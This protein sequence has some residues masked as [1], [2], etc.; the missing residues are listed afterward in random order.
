LCAIVLLYCDGK[1][2][3]IGILNNE[4]IYLMKNNLRFKKLINVSI[5]LL[6]TAI[7][8]AQYATFD[9]SFVIWQ[10]PADPGVQSKFPETVAP[11]AVLSGGPGTVWEGSLGSPNSWYEVVPEEHVDFS[12]AFAFHRIG[13][14]L[15]NH[16]P[17]CIPMGTDWS[18]TGC[19]EYA[20]DFFPMVARVTVTARSATGTYTTVFDQTITWEW[21]APLPYGGYGFYWWHNR[22]LG[23]NII[24][25]GDM[26]TDNWQS[27]NNYH[28][29]EFFMRFE[30]ISQPGEGDPPTG[31]P[32]YTINYVNEETAEAVSTDDEYSYNN[33]TYYSGQNNHVALTPGQT[34]YFRKKADPSKKQT[35]SVPSRP[36]I[37]NFTVDYVNERTSE[38]AS[39]NIEFSTNANL[40]GAT[41]GDGGYPALTPGVNMYF[42]KKATSS[43]FR[44]NI[45]SLT[46]P[47]RPGSPAFGIN[48]ASEQ[49]SGAVSSEYNYSVNSDMSGASQGTGAVLALTPGTNMYF[50]KRAIQGVAFRSQVQTLVVPQRPAGPGVGIDYVNERTNMVLGSDITYSPNS[51]MSGAVAGT[52]SYLTLVPGN[53][54]FFQQEATA[55]AF[56]TQVQELVIPARPAKPS[57]GIDY[58]NERTSQAI[59]SDMEYSSNAAMTSPVTG[60]GSPVALSPGTSKFFRMKAGASS[61]RSEIQELQ[62][63][64]R[65]PAPTFSINYPNETT[66]ETVGSGTQYSTYS[67]MSN[68]STGTGQVVNV[69]PG[70]NLYLRTMA[71]ASAFSSNIFQLMVPARPAPP[72]Y[73]IDYVNETTSDAVTSTDQYGQQPD[74][75]DAVSGTGIP[76]Q[77]LPGTSLYF[78]KGAT[79]SLF[80]SA[81]QTLVV[82]A[83]P[84]APAFAIDF[85]HEQTATAVTSGFRYSSNADMSGAVTGTGAK[86]PVAPLTILYFQKLPTATDFMSE[87]QTL[88]APGRPM[89]PSVGIDFINERTASAVDATLE[90]SL[91][92]NMQSSAS[93]SGDPIALIPGLDMYFRKKATPTGFAS[94][95]QHLDVPDRPQVTSTVSGTTTLYPFQVQVN[96][97][98]LGIGLTESGF[99]L[100]N[101]IVSNL[102]L[103]ASGSDLTVY[104]ADIRAITQDLVSIKIRANATQMGNFQSESFKV[105]YNG[106]ATG[107]EE[108]SMDP[109]FIEIYPNPS[110]G[111]INLR[112]SFGRVPVKV[113]LYAITGKMIYTGVHFISDGE[114]IDLR[115]APKGIYLI[116]FT[117]EGAT[118]IKKIILQ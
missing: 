53:T 110:E 35:L 44:S 106:E 58:M 102:S 3:R 14:V 118:S 41:T 86:V 50:Q 57:V 113:E 46:V 28:N 117:A 98:Q 114:F 108:T 38:S 69:T 74:L 88:M 66:S 12:R 5:L 37:P 49:T 62:V 65:D 22:H 16:D 60:A 32:N 71:T 4:R 26:P 8:T 116:H 78:R 107:F 34:T 25:Y 7:L 39:S 36:S 63:P 97:F 96:F 40:S 61:F 48:Y 54:L 77:V 112:G 17:L 11:R 10:E 111:I 73:G 31:I 55:S 2:R 84:A 103:E 76:I 91:T 33:S 67:N 19:P 43:S 100:Q 1:S 85:V 42:R 115:D 92:E 101:G 95:T 51:N 24:N 56:R 30:I 23:Y 109:D 80:S 93:G 20:P 27:P 9:I 99:E 68:A 45:Q 94:Q 82:P 6:F 104:S 13:L 87:I 72:A 89:A 64:A 52:G 21:Q 59:G 70:T 81:I 15:Y 29:G 79:S 105:T 18:D 90:Y 47:G 75:S 83:R